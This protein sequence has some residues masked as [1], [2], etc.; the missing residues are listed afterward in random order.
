MSFLSDYYFCT[1]RKPGTVLG[2]APS[3]VNWWCYHHGGS[4]S[5]GVISTQLI[6]NCR[7]RLDYGICFGRT[8]NQKVTVYL[9]GNEISSVV[10]GSVL[11]TSKVVEFDY[12]DSDTL[13]IEGSGIGAAL[14]FNSFSVIGCS[15]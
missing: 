5:H 14:Q 10:G 11:E 7:G 1:C 13:M 12:T 3:C 8:S 4:G 9:N 6:G 15:P 2:F